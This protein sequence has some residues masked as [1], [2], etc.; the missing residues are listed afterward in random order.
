MNPHSKE[1]TITWQEDVWWLSVELSQGGGVPFLTQNLTNF[2]YSPIPPLPIL[3]LFP[4]LCGQFQC[5]V[6]APHFHDAAPPRLVCPTTLSNA[7]VPC[8]CAKKKKTVSLSMSHVSLRRSDF[9][10]AEG[11]RPL[12]EICE[13]DKNENETQTPK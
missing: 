9:N 8:A 2:M 12:Q 13:F 7:G 10:S 3:V 1:L 6:G 4:K 11:S 5:N